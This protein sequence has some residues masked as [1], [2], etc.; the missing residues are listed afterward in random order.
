MPSPSQLED[1]A[2]GLVGL[3]LDRF[4]Q[5]MRRM[6]ETEY[7]PEDQALI[8]DPDAIA[9]EIIGDYDLTIWRIS[10]ERIAGENGIA[11][12]HPAVFR[13]LQVVD[14]RIQAKKPD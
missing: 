7:S 6:F 8:K 13:A 1:A 10:L 11:P 4:R 5:D 9:E 12:D 2:Q 14:Q 3:T